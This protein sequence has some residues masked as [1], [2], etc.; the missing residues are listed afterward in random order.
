[1]PTVRGFDGKEYS[2]AQIVD[3]RPVILTGGNVNTGYMPAPNTV[4]I[5]D[6][7]FYVPR[8]D[9]VFIDKEGVIGFQK[10]IPSLTPKLPEP[11]PNAMMLY[12]VYIP[13]YTFSYR[14]VKISKIENKRYTMRD[15]GKLE[16][17]IDKLE[18]YSIL[19]LPEQLVMTDKITD[20][21]GNERYKNGFLVDQFTDYSVADTGNVEFKSLKDSIRRALRPNTKMFNRKLKL[22]KDNSTGYK[23]RGSVLTLPY[24]HVLADEQ[25]FA[26]K[27]VS[28][29]ECFIFNKKGKLLLFP[30]HNTWS[31]TTREAKLEINIDTGT[32]AVEGLSNQ[33]NKV[34]KD[35]NDFQLANVGT[36]RPV[37][38][39][40]ESVRTDVDVRVADPVVTTQP[41]FGNFRWDGAAGITRAD[42]TGSRTTTSVATTTTTT[43]TAVRSISDR[44]SRIGKKT[45]T[46]TFDRVTDVK[47]LPFMKETVINFSAEGLMPNMKMYLFFSDQNV[48]ELASL[49]DAP[50]KPLATDE[51]GNLMGTVIIPSGMFLNG[52]KIV[53][54]TNDK[55]NSGDED[56]EL[57]HARH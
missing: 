1:M 33:I 12:K 10:G 47:V 40:E 54:I 21:Q 19:S 31:D 43:R 30:N 13:A 17:R 26:T 52:T 4:M 44:E 39:I 35:F 46:H 37:A 2:V 49:L 50:D 51:H 27:S 11:R 15:I 6:S 28:I 25:P 22:D 9:Y 20:A 57:C 18:Y 38:K 7:E 29:N 5:H 53:K 24:E 23:L 42:Q 55:T 56:M 14:D 3:F 48:T 45:E 32:E 41:L 34:Q 16:S 8:M 36:T